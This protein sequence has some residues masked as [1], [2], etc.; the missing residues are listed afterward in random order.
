[1]YLKCTTYAL[2]CW[3]CVLTQCIYSIEFNMISY[4]KDLIMLI[5]SGGYKYASNRSNSFFKKNAEIFYQQ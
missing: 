2:L 3:C 4:H 1:M 5:R